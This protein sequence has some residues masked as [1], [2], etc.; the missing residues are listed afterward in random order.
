MTKNETSE[1]LQGILNNDLFEVSLDGDCY[2]VNTNMSIGEKMWY[3]IYIK[4]V[5]DVYTV[6]DGGVTCFQIGHI[7]EEFEKKLNYYADKCDYEFK[8]KKLFKKDV[9]E[10]ELQ[11]AVLRLI[12]LITFAYSI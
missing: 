5:G 6:Y 9:K 11:I 2:F 4:P 7:S 8:N 3:E 1:K 12:Q 10:E